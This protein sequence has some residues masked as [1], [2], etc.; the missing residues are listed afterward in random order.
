MPFLHK[1]SSGVYMVE[2]RK[3]N[4]VDKLRT[5]MLDRLMEMH[6]REAGSW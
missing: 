4:N 6:H 3:C 2:K 1:V 5:V